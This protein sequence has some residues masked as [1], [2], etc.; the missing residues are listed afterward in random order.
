MPDAARTLLASIDT[1]DADMQLYKSLALVRGA[2]TA[3]L[4]DALV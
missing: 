1:M 4:R 3:Y 2:A